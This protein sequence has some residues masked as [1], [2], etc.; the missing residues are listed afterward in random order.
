VR[1]KIASSWTKSGSTLTLDVTVPPNATGVVYVPG[2][3]P[4]SVTVSGAT[5]AKYV[6]KQGTRLVYNVDSGSYRFTVRA[7]AAQGN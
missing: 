5:N 3:D 6:G 2:S 4:S 7:A 1:G